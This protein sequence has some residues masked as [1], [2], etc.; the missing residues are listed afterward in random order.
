[1]PT[2]TVYGLGASAVSEAAVRR[3]FAAKERPADNP[4]IVHMA[5]PRD[6]VSAV[7]RTHGAMR[8]A[9]EVFA[10]G[11]LTVVIPAPPW[12]VPEVRGGLPTVA[13]RVPANRLARE[14]IRAAAVPVAAPSANRS[15]RPSPTTG[16]M[17]LQEMSGRVAAVVDGGACTVGIESTII[18]EDGGGGVVVLRPGSISRERLAEVLQCPVRYRQGGDAVSPGAVYPHYRPVVPVILVKTE[19]LSTARAEALS[20]YRSAERGAPDTLVT[21][22][23]LER[24]GTWERYGKH[25]YREF[26]QAEQQG[27]AV[28]LAEIPRQDSAEGLY[29]RLLRA[30]TGT[31]T[32]G[33]FP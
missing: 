20:R 2:E 28:I 26:F 15:G 33:M 17:A 14:I 1:M 31:F 23:S 12:A 19:D 32:P 7:P 29:D 27:A 16:A 10:P 4:L 3:V 24:Y 21:V 9:L 22:L 13:L 11:P 8:A 30:A 5:D 25:L 6:A 18:A